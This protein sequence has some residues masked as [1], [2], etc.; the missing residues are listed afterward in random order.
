M[1]IH[2]MKKEEITKK[3]NGFYNEFNGNIYINNDKL[4]EIEKEYK[5]LYNK[6]KV[7]F[8]NY[9]FLKDYKNIYY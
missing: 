6:L 4:I 8:L 3:I 7:S 1:Y 2:F 5:E 9:P